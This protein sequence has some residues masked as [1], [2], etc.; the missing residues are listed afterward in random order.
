MPYAAFLNFECLGSNIRTQNSY[1]LSFAADYSSIIDQNKVLE[2]IHCADAKYLGL[3]GGHFI[4]KELLNESSI[5][6]IR[7]LRVP[8]NTSKSASSLL[9]ALKLRLLVTITN[10]TIQSFVIFRVCKAP[11]SLLALL[12]FNTRKGL[13]AWLARRLSF[14]VNAQRAPTAFIARYGPKGSAI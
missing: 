2:F 4:L 1:G 6:R 7:D 3:R 10:F 11:K 5:V 13:S 12:T 9:Y 8:R 14:A